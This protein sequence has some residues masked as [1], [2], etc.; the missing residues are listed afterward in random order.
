M[1]TTRIKTLYLLKDD[2]LCSCNIESA[3]N[4][5]QPTVSHHINIL[6]KSK[7]IN[8]RKEGAW[9]HYSISD[10]RIIEILDKIKVD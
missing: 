10:P 4:K 5:P 2:G 3:L 1:D 6:K 7:L 8:A 9:N